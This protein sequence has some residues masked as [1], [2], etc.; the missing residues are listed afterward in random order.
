[1]R[2]AAGDLRRYWTAAVRYRR[3]RYGL[4]YDEQRCWG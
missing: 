3:Y 4:T 2:G 1:M